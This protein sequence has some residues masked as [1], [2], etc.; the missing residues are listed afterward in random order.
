MVD[1]KKSI[2][3]S[4]SSDDP[5]MKKLAKKNPGSE[6]AQMRAKYNSP[7]M[8]K[9]RSKGQSG[10]W[11]KAKK[12]K[13][14]RPRP[15]QPRG[16]PQTGTEMS[17]PPNGGGIMDLIQ[18]VIGGSAGPVGG[19]PPMDRGGDMQT[20][21]PRQ[22]GGDM[23]GQMRTGQPMDLGRKTGD[24]AMDSVSRMI[25]GGGN[26]SQVTQRGAGGDAEA[27]IQELLDSSSDGDYSSSDTQA[28]KTIKA[29]NDSMPPE[30]LTKLLE[31]KGVDPEFIANVVDPNWEGMYD[32][33]MQDGDKTAA[34]FFRNEIGF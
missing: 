4:L 28:W 3:K 30:Q 22:P 6:I 11:D 13:D 15:M 20:P 10:G 23:A 16:R 31:Q 29:L 25:G 32:N 5:D 7:D 18:S 33:A 8:T 24:P 34:E 19:A 1:V 21:M 2:A 12:V 27:M 26:V 17:A 14:D 9:V